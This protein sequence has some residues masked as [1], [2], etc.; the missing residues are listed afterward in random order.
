MRYLES[1][2]ISRISLRNKIKYQF[3][4]NIGYLAKKQDEQK[5]CGLST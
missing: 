1:Y 3:T 4:N 5:K 2:L